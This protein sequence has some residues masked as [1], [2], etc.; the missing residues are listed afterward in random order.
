MT[1]KGGKK[2]YEP[3]FTP[4]LYTVVLGDEKVDNVVA[5]LKTCQMALVVGML[6]NP[7]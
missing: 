1:F 3:H 4:L 6:H 5:H 2:S 7:K